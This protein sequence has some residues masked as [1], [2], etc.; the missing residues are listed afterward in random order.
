MRRGRVAPALVLIVLVLGLSEIGAADANVDIVSVDA[1]G[2]LEP[3][4]TAD[5]AVTVKN[6]AGTNVHHMEVRTEGFD[7]VKEQD[8]WGLDAGESDTLHFFLDAPDD[9]PGTHEI[10]ITAQS[11]DSDG[12][13]I[14]GEKR[15]IT[16][17]VEESGPVV[18]PGE[19]DLDIKSLAAPATVMAG[20]TITLDVTAKNRGSGDMGGLHV[21]VDA[22]GRTVTE[23]AGTLPG[24]SSKT[25]SVD[26]PVP[27]AASGRETATVTVSTFEAQDS[28]STTIS[29]SAVQA[30]L[31]LRQKTVTVGEP[32]T[33]SGILTRRNTRA[34]LFYGG[35]FEAPVFSDATGHYVHTITPERPGVFTVMLSVGNVRI[36]RFLTVRPKM[37]VE[38]ISTPE[39][40]GVNSIFDVCSKISRATEGEAELRLSVDGTVKK[41]ATVAVDAS[42]EHCF[43]TSLPTTGNHT[44]TV[45]IASGGVTV[46]ESTRV[47]AVETGLS[48]SVFP[49]QLTLTV[50]QAGVFQV[51]IHN[52]R[53]RKRQF[54][55]NVTGF[56]ELE[57]QTAGRIELGRGDRRQAVVRVVPESTGKHSGTITVSSGGTVLTESSVSVRAVQNP[58][59]K[60]PVIGGTVRA[61]SD[62]AATVRDLPKRQKQGLL[63][64]VAGS[65]L[66]GIWYWRRRRSA[67]M[68]PQY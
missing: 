66:L 53:L 56:E 30:S 14:G 7:Q 9:Q 12:N 31:Q 46:S 37:S 44:I 40:V 62:V 2:F 18:T 35:N 38:E 5:I 28:V 61:A 34:D 11:R 27:A 41:T 55:I 42:T 65:I 26:V 21:A 49:D 15:T 39:R 22:F 51:D 13:V 19:G 59:L 8:L 23:K 16:I 68:E 54:A 4:Q 10:D 60:N 20:E 52:D 6:T 64:A 67:V 45:E 36:E 63:G 48:A 47:A 29:I 33:V 25:V 1:P 32:V 3:N 58:A 24:K 50:G 57:P 43:S 17:D